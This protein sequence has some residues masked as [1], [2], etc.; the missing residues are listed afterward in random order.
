MDL[1]GEGVFGATGWQSCLLGS[2]SLS[3]STIGSQ[4]GNNPLENKQDKGSRHLSR[5]NWALLHLGRL[6]LA[7]SALGAE[8]GCW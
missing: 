3:W 8:G 4:T 5:I 6:E 1:I 7:V 2:M